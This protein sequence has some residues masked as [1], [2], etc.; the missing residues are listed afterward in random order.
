MPSRS[1]IAHSSR[2]TARPSPIL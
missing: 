2:V 1:R